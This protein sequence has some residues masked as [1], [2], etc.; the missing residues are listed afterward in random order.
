MHLFSFIY[1]IVLEA[2]KYNE[3]FIKPG[4][5]LHEANER[6]WVFI[7]AELEKRF[8]EHQLNDLASII[9]TSGT[10]GEP[11]GVMLDHNNFASSLKAHEIELEVDE[12][13]VD[14]F[15]KVVLLERHLNQVFNSTKTS[16]F[17][18]FLSMPKK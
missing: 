6:V 12:N 15:M 1:T 18:E 8:F 17:I 5:L 14:D 9:Y 10:T 4:V 11:K 16:N 3:D 7:E 2:Q 13:D